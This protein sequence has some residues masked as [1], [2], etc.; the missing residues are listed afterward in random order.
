[1][2]YL[3][4]GQATSTFCLS[5]K[6]KERTPAHFIAAQSFLYAEEFLNR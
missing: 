3:A 4:D 6:D 5:R 2:V 1:M